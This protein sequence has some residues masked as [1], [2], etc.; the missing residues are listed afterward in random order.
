[1]IKYV[2]RRFDKMKHGG[3]NEKENILSQAAGDIL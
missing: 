3:V 1:L 2:L